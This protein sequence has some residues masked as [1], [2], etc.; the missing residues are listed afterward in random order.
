[1]VLSSTVLTTYSEAKLWLV[2][3]APTIFPNTDTLGCQFVGTSMAA[4]VANMFCV[5]FDVI[6]SRVQDGNQYKGM[7]DC[8]RKSVAA[9][10]PMVL[11]K[12]YIPALVKLAPCK[13]MDGRM[14]G[15]QIPPPYSSLSPLPLLMPP[16]CN[17][18]QP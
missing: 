4:F 1:M 9:E 16:P 11:Y 12:G 15:R 18:T 2:K 17:Q 13:Y 10:G 14:A 5:P 3:T 8:V 6:K 7:M